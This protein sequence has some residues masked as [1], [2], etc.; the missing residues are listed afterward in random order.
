MA[1]NCAAFASASRNQ[2]L[3]FGSDR[4]A[5]RRRSASSTG[6][7]TRVKPWLHGTL[8]AGAIGADG[9]RSRAR[10]GDGEQRC[11]AQ[12]V[13]VVDTAG[14]LVAFTIPPPPLLRRLAR[15]RGALL[16]SHLRRTSLTP[17][18]PAEPAQRHGVDVLLP[19]SCLVFHRVILPN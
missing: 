15:R 13:D 2:A 9:E 4:T 8:G 19:L 1:S 6:C 10:D 11:R 7:G 5:Q 16:R 14:R 18:D 3:N 17:A 12:D